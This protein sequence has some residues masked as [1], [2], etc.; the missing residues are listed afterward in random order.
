MAIGVASATASA[1]VRITD[2]TAYTLPERFV[3]A[4]LWRLEYGVH[5]VTGLEIGTYTL[6]YLTWA[7][8]IRSGNAYAEYQWYRGRRWT[9]ATSLGLTHADFGGLDIDASI[10]VVPV[11]LLAAMRLGGRLT[12]SFGA[13][14]TL[15]YGE[16]EYNSESD[17]RF[18]GAVALDNLQ[19]W[20]AIM[21]RLSSRWTLVVE[22]RGIAS[23]SG[24]ASGDFM[25]RLDDRTTVEVAATGRA[26]IDELRGSTTTVSLQYSREHLRFRFGGGY[27]NYVLPV[28]QMVVPTAI[29][30]PELDLYWVF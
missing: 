5:G 10:S 4:G 27:G 21:L 18:R 9:L 29:P 16:G 7:A 12:L 28:L 24:R 20:A 3:R 1:D 17:D 15:F 14:Y 11:K 13:M 26:S 30:Y 23:T 2:D 6:P 8:G 19:G 22:G 25:T